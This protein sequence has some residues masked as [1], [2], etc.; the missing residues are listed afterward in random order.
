MATQQSREARLRKAKLHVL[1]KVPFF[2]S[3]VATMPVIFDDTVLSNGHPTACTNG[4]VIRWHPEDFDALEDMYLPTKLCHEVIH[5]LWGHLWR[6]PEGGDPEEWNKACDHV[7]NLTLKQFSGVVMAKRLADPFPFPPPHDAY[8]AD[9]RFEG[10]CEEKVYEILMKEKG[11]K[12]K[13]PG[14]KQ[15]PGGQQGQGQGK[16]KPQPGKGQGQPQPAPHSMPPFGQFDVPKPGTQAAKDQEKL[17]NTWKDRLIQAAAMGKGRGDTPACISQMV[18][19]I[20]NP[21]VDWWTILRE[22]LRERCTD[23]WDMVRHN[24]P[25]SDETGFILPSLHSEKLGTVV[26][27]TDTSGSIGCYP[28]L[29]ARFQCEK[30]SMLADLQPAKLVDIYCDTIVQKVAEYFPGET[31]SKDVPGGGGTSFEPVFEYVETLPEPPKCLVYLTD[32]DGSFP[33][34]APEYPVLW[35]SYGTDKQAPFGQTIRGDV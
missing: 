4:K 8:C 3:G 24:I 9:P 16:G 15:G 20:V 28:E 25:L 35:V 7:A 21:K 34:T 17:H 5:P 22:F 1:F 13:D 19:Q 2:A 27:A 31:M 33:D 11:Q 10:M 30:Q 32:L 29:V 12:G 6:M 23:D 18:D 26:F 14:G